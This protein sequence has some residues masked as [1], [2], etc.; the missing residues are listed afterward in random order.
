M[1]VPLEKKTS[2][3]VEKLN[4]GR[5]GERDTKSMNPSDLMSEIRVECLDPS[6]EGK[7]RSARAAPR[8][9]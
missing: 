1:T 5:P 3:V 8:G 9:G 7:V 2:G 4:C 6:R